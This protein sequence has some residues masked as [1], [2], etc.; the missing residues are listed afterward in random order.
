M[1]LQV[2]FGFSYFKIGY[3]GKHVLICFLLNR[4]PEFQMLPLRASI[5]FFLCLM[6]CTSVYILQYFMVLC[7]SQLLKAMLFFSP[8]M[9]RKS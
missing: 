3:T 8:L 4:A 9:L 1:I 2:Y 5:Y 6:I 7:A